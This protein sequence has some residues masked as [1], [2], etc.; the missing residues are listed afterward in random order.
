MESV[1]QNLIVNARDAFETA[2]VDAARKIT[3][4]A[5][6]STNGMMIISV[7]DNAGGIPESVRNRIFDPFFTTKEVGRGTGLGLSLV[8]G[9][10]KNHGGSIEVSS[11]VGQGT[12]FDI[13]I[14]TGSLR[15]LKLA[16]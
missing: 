9:I 12:T 5:K 6:L 7:E 8:H 1:L 15:T 16:G 2:N 14:P 13:F 4:S 3:I 11:I 10:V